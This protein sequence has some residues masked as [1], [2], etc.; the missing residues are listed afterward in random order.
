MKPQSLLI[1]I[2]SSFLACLYLMWSALGMLKVP[3]GIPGLQPGDCSLLVGEAWAGRLGFVAVAVAAV[4]GVA[5]VD[6]GRV[7][8]AWAVQGVLQPTPG[9]GE[10]RHLVAGSAWP[11]TV[12]ASHSVSSAA[13][14]YELIQHADHSHPENSNRRCYM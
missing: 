7:E 3:V 2:M 5:D 14:L 12:P 13:G 9:V 10:A 4:E 8:E 11:A 1:E 6:L